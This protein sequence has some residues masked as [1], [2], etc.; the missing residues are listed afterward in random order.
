MD[1]KVIWHPRD[2]ANAVA[3]LP[4]DEPL[5]CRTVLVPHERV[6]HV[7]RREL[8]RCGRSEVLAGTRFIAS[9]HAAVE[10][11]RAAGADFEPGEEALRAARL[12]ALFRTQLELEHF[13]LELLRAMPGWNEAFAHTLSDLEGAGLR[14]ADVERDS[15]RL[16]D[17]AAIWQA[18]DDSAGR[19]WTPQ[20]IHSE[21]AAE[22]ERAPE[23]WPYPGAVLAS[24]AS[25][26][27][28]AEA[29]FFR[30]LPRATLGL[31]GA[32]PPRERHFAR[33]AALFGAT[34]ADVLRSSDAPRASNSE[35]DLLAAFLFEPPPVLAEEARPRSAGPDGTVELEDHA[36]V[37]A[38][39]EAT[40]DWVA[41]QV[42][43]GTPL[44]DVAVL[45]PAPDPLAGLVAERL[46]R[47]PWH[48]G[49]FPVHVA[50]GLP[51]VGTARGARALAVVRALRAHLEAAALAQVLPALCTS[52][53]DR[54]LAH[55]AATDLVWSLGTVGGNAARPEGALEWSLRAAERDAELETELAAAREAEEADGA[56]GRRASDLE[57][58][59][60]DL[61]AVRPALDA[62]V[63]VARVA[64]GGK[65]LADL[66]PALREFL[67]KWLRQPGD[68][69]RVHEV[70]EERLGPLT[71]DGACGELVGEDALR[72]IEATATAARVPCG[73]FGDPAVFVGSVHDAAPLA[74]AAARVIGLSE[75]RLPSAFRV[76]P[77]LPD[78][79]REALRTAGAGAAGRATMPTA[80]D[81]ALLDLHALDAAIRGAAERVAL[82]AARHDVERSQREPSSVILEAAAALGRPDRTTGER[83]ATIP[84]SRS[85]QRDGFAPARADAAAFRCEKPLGEAAWQDGVSRGELG[86]P[87]RW[88]GG[89]ATDLDRVAR[90]AAPGGPGPM[91]GLFGDA[92]LGLVMP[93]LSADRPISP[94]AIETLLGCPHEF[95]LGRILGLD[96]PARPPPQREIGQPH[97][98]SLFHAAAAAFYT[99]HGDA[100]CRHEGSLPAWQQ[101]ADE[102]VQH[103]FE[104]FLR[105][106]PLVGEAVRTQ[107]LSRLRRDVRD[108]LEYDWNGT[109]KASRYAG[110]ERAFGSKTGVRLP[111]EKPA[112]FVR[113]RIDRLD[114]TDRT[115]LVRDLKTGRAHPRIGAK[116]RP[117]PDV[118][119]QIAVYGLVV[120]A[121]AEEWKLPKRIAAAYAYVGRSA[122]AE[123]SWRADFHDVLEPAA[124]RWLRVAAALLDGRSFPRTPIEKDCAFCRFRP[125]CGDR[126]RERAAVLLEG[127][128]G[129]LAEFA[130]L[131]GAGGE[132]A[133]EST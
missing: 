57:R 18:L 129:V 17:V 91:D 2:L 50:G 55:G 104:A 92:D 85:L 60:A 28:E 71:A 7:L 5:P 75:G 19:S 108:L 110:A 36:G 25:D 95:L 113:G 39:L 133:E 67:R 65:R 89:R 77:V 44:E 4:A 74:F 117:A 11:L 122:P 42:E 38:E 126:A 10:V 99:R 64:A 100:F 87:P 112:L 51:L 48:A 79:L 3:A 23:H 34:A 24:A 72:L 26:L 49:E 70:L 68:G 106:Y 119:L 114:A 127:A 13:S 56:T 115:T 29:R 111:L 131:K 81:R 33:V 130:E 120:Q 66:W 90:V 54:H 116:S 62:L 118:D 78:P 6:A 82:S 73:R 20:R 52:D 31:S 58:L 61:R 47:L 9:L 103:E 80:A 83:N 132:R 40:A 98:G 109:T 86:V 125:V 102:T 37:E 14:P 105:Q 30:A 69:P 107:Q 22:L 88:R 124:L 94:S 97:Y 27:T 16:R 63:E 59:L 76:D 46:A 12:L 45:V 41:R 53:P 35:R 96:E 93:G 121:L 43:L 32:R 101:R 15:A 8:V 128:K 1:V 84:D 123:R 21:A